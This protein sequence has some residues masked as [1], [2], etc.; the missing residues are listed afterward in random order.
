MRAWT[1][2]RYNAR[3]EL[4]LRPWIGPVALYGALAISATLVALAV[5]SYLAFRPGPRLRRA[6]LALL[7]GGAAAQALLAALLSTAQ[8]AAWSATEIGRLLLPA[9]Q[10]WGYFLGYVGNRYWMAFVLAA[11][12]AGAWYGFLR[13][14][15]SHS[16]R[17]FDAGEIEMTTLLVFAVGWPGGLVLVPLALVSVV[18]VSLARTFV[19]KRELT[20]LGVPF[21]VAAIITLAWGGAIRVLFT[22]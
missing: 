11:V 8:Y 17:Y 22:G 4:L 21:L 5:A 10:G 16:E 7:L 19:L 15:G 13:A 12:C 18:V 1:I 14:V 6:S 2:S 3:M 20:T 9:Q